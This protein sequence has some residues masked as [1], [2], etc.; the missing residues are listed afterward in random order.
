M[1]LPE[2]VV[3]A[4]REAEEAEQQYEAA[5]AREAA[6]QHEFEDASFQTPDAADEPE[7]ETPE[8][9]EEPQSDGDDADAAEADV[10]ESPDKGQASVWEQRYK[11]LLGKYNAEVPRLTRDITTLQG[12]VTELQAAVR[13]RGE[14]GEGGENPQDGSSGTRVR[15][16]EGYKK[17]LKADEVDQYE[18][19]VLEF[20][21]RL[22]RGEA[23]NLVTPYVKSLQD[24]LEALESSTKSRTEN[25][26]WSAVEEQ[27]PGAKQI[28][29]TDPLWVEFLE[30]VDPFSGVKYRDIGERA[31]GS[32]D[33]NRTVALFQ[34]YT[35][36][37]GEEA[38]ADE[39]DDG[40]DDE[41][42]PPVK[43]SQSRGGTRSTK[44]SANQTYIK[45]TDIEGFYS[46]V[47]RGKYV[48]RE[49]AMH[50]REAIIEQA[51]LEGRVIPTR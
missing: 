28:N 31:L 47:A 51:V 38:E 30:T 2:A 6:E 1:A 14:V 3:Q 33:V 46:D 29:E 34:Q 11:T 36:D 7:E 48:G 16:A 27:V 8:E 40:G 45:S 44:P 49:E 23:E 50:K 5:L 42:R 25:Q 43:P 21:S 22:A 17:Y 39:S 32:G 10:G 13:G 37:A 4:Q 35:G 15:P 20:Q 9:T 26:F 41:D 19:S 18:E 12:F 24:R